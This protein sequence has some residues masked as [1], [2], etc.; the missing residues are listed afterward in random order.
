MNNKLPDCGCGG[1]LKSYGRARPDPR[2]ACAECGKVY[3]AASVNLLIMDREVEDIERQE[4]GEPPIT[5]KERVAVARQTMEEA[6]FH[7]QRRM[8]A[9]CQGTVLM[10]PA[11]LTKGHRQWLRSLGLTPAVIDRVM[12]SELRGFGLNSDLYC[13]VGDDFRLEISAANGRDLRITIGAV[14]RAMELDGTIYG[15]MQQG[16]KGTLWKPVHNLGAC[17]VWRN[18]VEPPLPPWLSPSSSS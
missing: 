15:G 12:A 16:E 1:K 5:E 11:D 2:W 14:A 8:F 17:S 10:A 7:R 6:E 18:H 4:R 3:T 13:Y 9:C